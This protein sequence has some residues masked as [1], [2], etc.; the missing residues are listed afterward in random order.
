MTKSEYL[1]KVLFTEDRG[2]L[3]HTDINKIASDAWDAA[4]EEA[5]MWLLKNGFVDMESSDTDIHFKSG[6]VCDFLDAM[7]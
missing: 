6:Y 5:K 7:K 3:D 2:W 1:D 4:I